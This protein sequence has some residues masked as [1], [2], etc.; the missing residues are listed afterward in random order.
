MVDPTWEN[1]TGG[2][3]YFNKLDLNHFV[4]AIK[5]SSSSNPPPAGSYKYFGQ[6]SHD[7][8]VTLSDTDFLGKPQLDVAIE[9]GQP[10]FA[11]F[12]GK[13]KVKISNV[14][15]ALFP[16]TLF[17]LTAQKLSILDASSKELGPIPAFGTAEFDFNIRTRSLFDSYQDEVVVLVGE[18]KFTKEVL[19]KPFFLFQTIP[20]ITVGVVL[21]MVA[22]YLLVLGGLVYRRR[23][24]KKTKDNL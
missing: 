14:G 5:G 19:V 24:L 21:M 22:I 15:N 13:I 2:V 7:V 6:D 18:L 8:K 1:T 11:G 4:F 9:A 12:P 17:G 20:L 23:F 16:S 10:I 3:D